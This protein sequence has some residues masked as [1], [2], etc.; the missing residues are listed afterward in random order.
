MV[1]LTTKIGSLTLKN[2]IMPA[3]G[4]FSEDLSEVLDLNKLGAHVTK[5][6]T[7]EKRGGNPTPR[8]RLY[9]YARF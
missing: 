5:T 9:H 1:N 2:P 8:T 6:I 4:T 3:S 7:E